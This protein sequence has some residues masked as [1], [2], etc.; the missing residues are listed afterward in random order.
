[1]TYVRWTLALLLIGAYAAAL[2]YSLPSRDIVRVLGTEV[3]RVAEERTD[4]QGKEVLIT[5]D[6]M[7][8]NT[9]TP[10]GGERVY[11]NE[12]TDWSFPWYLKFDSADVAARAENLKST[13]D[14]PRWVIVTHYG[15]RVPYFSWFPNAIDLE[16]AEGPGQDLTPWFNIVFVTV[17]TLALI[18]LW[19][20]ARLA[21][22]RNVDPVIDEIEER[23]S[24]IARVWRGLWR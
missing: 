16:R 6:Q 4:P 10:S 14:A 11:R 12:D 20:L 7:R 24:A 9:I 23:G 1:M 3:V 15:W 18:T 8:I 22:R 13:E 21:F 5:R 17:L 2:H 19:R